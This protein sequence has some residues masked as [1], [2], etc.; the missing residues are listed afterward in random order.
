LESA[1]VSSTDYYHRSVATSGNFIRV[2]TSQEY[3]I[4]RSDNHDDDN[5]YNGDNHNDDDEDDDEDE[6]DDDD[7]D[8]NGTDDVIINDNYLRKSFLKS[9]QLT[10]THQI[11][12][13]V[14]SAI[15]IATKSQQLYLYLDQ[16]NY[17]QFDKSNNI[18]SIANRIENVLYDDHDNVIDEWNHFL[19]RIFYFHDHY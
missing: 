3:H 15:E 8:N 16:K 5:N 18:Q 4:S 17:E 19:E 6:E 14:R 7:D 1:N 10:I 2:S 9:F 12:Q 13:Y 11:S